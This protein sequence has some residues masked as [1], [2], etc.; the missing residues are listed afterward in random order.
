MVAKK[1]ETE[2]GILESSVRE[3]LEMSPATTEVYCKFEKSA[4]MILFWRKHGVEAGGKMIVASAGQ[5][6]K[7]QIRERY[8]SR[9]GQCTFAGRDYP[10]ID[11]RRCKF[12]RRFRVLTQEQLRKDKTK[13]AS[14]V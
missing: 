4:E 13:Q 11:F 2:V 3:L 1:H 9:A 5:V 6:F 10:A 7:S 14:S 12:A 8:C